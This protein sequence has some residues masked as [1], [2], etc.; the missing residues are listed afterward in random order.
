MDVEAVLGQRVGFKLCRP[1]GEQHSVK[2]DLLVL[3]LSVSSGEPEAPPPSFYSTL[4]P[5]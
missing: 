5:V 2:G 1:E 3:I 4:G